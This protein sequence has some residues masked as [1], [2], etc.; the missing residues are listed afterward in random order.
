MELYEK[1]GNILYI[2]NILKKYSD[3]E[4]LLQ[5]KDIKE[6]IKELYDVDIDP[7]TIRRNI[8][9]LKEKFAYDI[10]TYAENKEGYYIL[11]DPE[12]DFEP[13]EIRAIIDQFSYANYI[14]SSVANGIIKKCKN[15][16]NIYENEKFKDYKIIANDTKTDN[17][18]VIKNIEDISKAIYEKK[19][20]E[21]TY[22][23]YELNN[24]LKKVNVNTIKCSP[25]SII[26]SM[27]QFYLI[28][29]KDGAPTMYTYR[30]DRMKKLN[31]LDESLSKRVKQKEVENY[32][33]TNIA[34]FG[35]DNEKIEFN[36]NMEL[37]DMVIE[38][39]GKDIVLTKVDEHTFK[40]KVNASINGFKF[41]TLRNLENVKIVKPSKLKDQI[42]K[43]ISNYK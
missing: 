14:T 3:E 29:L 11:R 37:L 20:I 8:N 23:K 30:L 41:F 5:I 1:N 19:K 21:F 22:W 28:C 42:K 10:S 36:C 15:M 17:I 9:L 6:K 2:L 38:Q 34:M 25:Y 24:G 33:K 39:F 27:Q 7:R 13:G 31:I 32:I 4:H 40:A 26:Y 16:L 35:G 18:E 12:T 43:I